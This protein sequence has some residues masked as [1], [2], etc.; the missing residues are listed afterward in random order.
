MASKP[1]SG[2]PK[3]ITPREEHTIYREA[4][5]MP[6]ITYQKLVGEAGLDSPTHHR[7]APSRSTIYRVLKKRGLTN[8]VAAVRPKLKP[9]HIVL[10]RQFER[11]HRNFRWHQQ[12]VK[13][14]DECS[15]ERGSGQ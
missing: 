7:K 10:R 1:R 5:K 11:K 3:I 15:I 12:T 14:S 6:K 2:R 4:R 8:R 13:F 9:E